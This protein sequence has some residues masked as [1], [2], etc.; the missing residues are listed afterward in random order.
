VDLASF[1]PDYSG[2]AVPDSHGVPFSAPSHLN[3][4]Q[5][6]IILITTPE[7]MSNITTYT[8]LTII[9]GY[10]IFNKLKGLANNWDSPFQSLHP[11]IN[12]IL[13]KGREVFVGEI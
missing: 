8:K 1:V 11:N 13:D 3:T 12:L 5:F 6:Q 4:Y 7:Q 9:E 2:V 10:S